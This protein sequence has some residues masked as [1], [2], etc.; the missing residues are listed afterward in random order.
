M[1]EKRPDDK[2]W[3]D[4]PSGEMNRLVTGL[5]AKRRMHHLRIAAGISTAVVLLIVAGNLAVSTHDDPVIGGI[6][7]QKVESLAQDYLDNKLDEELTARVKQHVK[8]CRHCRQEFQRMRDE[9]DQGK[10]ADAVEQSRDR[11][12][13]WIREHRLI[14]DSMR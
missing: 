9:R 12:A 6:S 1:N 5:R 4:C 3:G 14:A 10:V 2:L 8:K 13:A 11:N 7:C